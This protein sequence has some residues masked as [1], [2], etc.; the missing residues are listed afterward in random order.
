MTILISLLL[1]I[2]LFILGTLILGWQKVLSRTTPATDGQSKSI[3]V[4][5]PFRNEEAS[6]ESLIESLKGISYPKDR[7]QV[8]FVNDHSTDQSPNMVQKGIDGQASFS[9]LSLPDGVTGKKNALTLGVQTTHADIVATTDA[10]CILPPAWLNAI[11]DSFNDSKTKLAFG[12]VKLTPN[13]SFFSHLQAVEFVSLI[14]SAASTNALGFFTMCNGANLSFHREI[15]LQ[16]NGYEG[17]MEIPSG[18]DEFL[19]RKVLNKYPNGVRFLN[20]AG[21]VVSTKF[22]PTWSQFLNQRLRW[23]GKWKHNNNFASRGLAVF[24][25]LSQCCFV[26]LLA[27]MIVGR[28]NLWFGIALMGCK[29]LLE[30]FFLLKVSNFLNALWS[31]PAFLFLQFSYP[32]YVIVVGILAQS[33][34]YEWK[35]RT[36][37]HKRQRP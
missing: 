23:A 10:D 11:N 19:A 32:F 37:S 15:F 25:L 14:G 6:L 4:V 3:C 5:I 8:I 26:L 20:S 31:W 7:F 9:L 27:G 35:G 30:S 12:G 29:M 18:D 21:A 24:I 33:G 2:Y 16:V 1:I 34:T 22:Q 13:K 36:L 17:N 28:F